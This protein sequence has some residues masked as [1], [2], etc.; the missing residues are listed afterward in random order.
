M[1]V[2][3]DPAVGGLLTDRGYRLHG[4]E[5]VLGR[6]L[7]ADSREP[8]ASAIAIDTARPSPEDIVEWKA[9]PPVPDGTYRAGPRSVVMLYAGV[10]RMVEPAPESRRS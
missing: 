6:A 3:T 4:F 5:H 8:I 1:S 9:A 2:L 7:D 10:G